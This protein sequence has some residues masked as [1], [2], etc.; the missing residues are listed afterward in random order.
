MT[1]RWLSFVVLSVGCATGGGD[2][3]V[4]TND[5]NAPPT[6]TSIDTYRAPYDGA[7]YDGPR[8]AIFAVEDT[9][10]TAP[11]KICDTPAGTTVTASGAYMSAPEMTVDRNLGTAWNAGDYLGWLRV[12]FPAPIFVDRVRIA[13]HAAPDCNIVYTIHAASKIGE[14]TRAVTGSGTWLEP[15]AIAP[16]TYGELLI[17]VPRA[18]SWIAINEVRVFDSTGACP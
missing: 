1:S 2:E 6:D 3:V 7:Q 4:N 12:K 10:P 18:D 5:A 15:I 13:A 17:D 16:G 9:A 8:D 14:G 11:P